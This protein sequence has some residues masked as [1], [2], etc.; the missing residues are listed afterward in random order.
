MP[1]GE[2]YEGLNR[3]VLGQEDVGFWISTTAKQSACCPASGPW[4]A[5]LI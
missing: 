1:P 5:H 4:P 3:R 2:V